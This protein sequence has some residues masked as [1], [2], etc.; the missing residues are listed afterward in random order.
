MVE[1]LIYFEESIGLTNDLGVECE[2]K[3]GVK[4]MP[5]ISGLST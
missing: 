3:R 2:R 1:F 5:K 4:E